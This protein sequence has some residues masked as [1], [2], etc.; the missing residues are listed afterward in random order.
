MFGGW[1][2][3]ACQ[4]AKK[5]L[6]VIQVGSEK[7]RGN[8]LSELHMHTEKNRT[9]KT[10]W[11]SS[12]QGINQLTWASCQLWQQCLYISLG[13]HISV[14]GTARLKPHCGTRTWGCPVARPPAKPHV[15]KV[16]SLVWHRSLFNEGVCRAGQWIMR[17]VLSWQVSGYVNGAIPTWKR[18]W[19]NAAAE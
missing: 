13:S 9:G 16:H 14:G 11:D 8:S 3:L 18:H 1:W 4:E 2:G 10:V 7:Q 19:A 17:T 12:L 5:S 6:A 15:F